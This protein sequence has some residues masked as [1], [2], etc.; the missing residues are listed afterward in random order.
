M[1]EA[2]KPQIKLI[3][4]LIK[5]LIGPSEGCEEVLNVSPFSKYLTGFI[6]PKDFRE[7][8]PNFALQPIEDGDDEEAQEEPEINFS[9]LIRLNPGNPPSSVGLLFTVNPSDKNLV[10]LKIAVSAAVYLRENNQNENSE[11][12][13]RRF[14]RQPFC[15]IFEIEIPVKETY[16]HR[17][18]EVLNKELVLNNDEKINLKL[19]LD[20][21]AVRSKKGIDIT[22]V[23][24]NATEINEDNDPERFKKQMAATVYQPQI[25]INLINGEL[26]SDNNAP[27]VKGLNCAAVYKEEDIQNKYKEEIENGIL[28]EIFGWSDG[29]CCQRKGEISAEEL[30]YFKT[31]DIRTEFLPIYERI[32][33]NFE[34]ESCKGILTAQILAENPDIDALEECFVSEYEKWVNESSFE[35][36]EYKEKHIEIIRRIKESLDLLRKDKEVRLA[37]S[38]ANK[39][40]DIQYRWKTGKPLIWRSFQLAYLLFVLKSVADSSDIY[41]DYC[42]LLYVPTGG[43]KT[44]AYLAV[45]SFYLALRRLKE[46]KKGFG[47]GVISRYTLRLLS[48][49]QFQ[50]AA[51]VITAAEYLRAIDW[52]PSW[53]EEAKQTPL[54]GT[55]RFSIGLWVG[56]NITPNTYGEALDILKN[57]EEAR[58]KKKPLPT[59]LTVCPSCGSILALPP[60]TPEQEQAGAKG[61]PWDGDKKFYIPVIADKDCAETLKQHQPLKIA[62]DIEIE[63]IPF[64][65]VKSDLFSDSE[66]GILAVRFNKNSLSYKD[67]QDL[68]E[69]EFTAGKKFLKC[70]D[71][72]SVNPAFPGYLLTFFGSG[73]KQKFLIHCPNPEC[74]LNNINTRYGFGYRSNSDYPE[75]LKGG[76][77]FARLIHYLEIKS[78]LKEI[79][80]NL[81]RRKYSDIKKL[82]DELEAII[83]DEP[84]NIQQSINKLVKKI[85][86][87]V[88]SSKKLKKND[89]ISVNVNIFINIENNLKNYLKDK[90]LIPVLTVDEEL[91]KNP[92]SL[93]IATVDKF[94]RLPFKSDIEAIFGRLNKYN[95]QNLEYECQHRSAREE[96]YFTPPGLILQDELHL[97]QGPLGSLVGLYETVVDALCSEVDAPSPM[98]RVPDGYTEIPGELLKK[99]P[100]YIASTATISGADVQIKALF[101]RNSFIFPGPADKDGNTFFSRIDGSRKLLLGDFGGRIYI[102]L[103]PI[104]RSYL[105]SQVRIYS[106]LLA[107][108]FNHLSDSEK[109]YYGSVVGYYNAIKELA[110]GRRILDDD[111]I[112]R[113]NKDYGLEINSSLN[114]TELSGRLP[115]EILPVYLK[116][117]ESAKT[118]TEKPDV[119]LTTSMFG[120]GVDVP[121]LSL[122]LVNGQP[123]LTADYI[124]A[125]GRVGRKKVGVIVTLYKPSRPRDF[126][127]FEHFITYHRNMDKYVEAPSVFPF[128]QRAMNKALG[129]VSVA[130]LR[131][132]KKVYCE[133]RD[134]PEFIMQPAAQGDIDKVV[135]ILKIRAFNQ[136][137]FLKVEPEEII[138]KLIEAEENSISAWKQYYQSSRNNLVYAELYP[139]RDVVLGDLI[140]E[141]AGKICIFK[142]VPQSLRNV[143]EEISY[144]FTCKKNSED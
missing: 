109:E 42:D 21:R 6:V 65:R 143:E 36:E 32:F 38:F 26:I 4:N 133:W 98:S 125:T 8:D 84:Q 97:I 92:P 129:P 40:M 103:L 121:Y 61:I 41:R 139:N 120:T 137:H 93:L 39:V 80:E 47:T 136:P 12:G 62:K 100:K 72:I 17:R 63:F 70:F 5:D 71:P 117:L 25:R 102:G 128:S 58:K 49:Q 89:K 79:K 115:S 7:I 30:E 106:S 107:T 96:Y 64:K 111:V 74:D 83:N 99:Y 126:S 76:I 37:F 94:A 86:E 35:K 124:Q 105:T 104:G 116:R 113:L 77:T 55:E 110:G 130:Y 46:E 11:E 51:G 31:P 52:K 2:L 132:S 3:R 66:V 114:I 53:L 85:N 59:I 15:K 123:K 112:D 88:R 34:M 69:K 22:A 27:K 95:K 68:F 78:V 43:G 20:I 131:L 142:R 33:P 60:D 101:N 9:E 140:H 23:L 1:A 54:W 73:K 13:K 56:R 29:I 14:K 45:I 28:P 127:H 122:M 108:K 119:L 18:F 144:K 10:K 118:H 48:V 67:I 75:A 57:P 134:K 91:Y 44:E 16:F 81:K 90:V 50:R 82:L 19:F 87:Y 141:K 24:Y 135:N 138:R